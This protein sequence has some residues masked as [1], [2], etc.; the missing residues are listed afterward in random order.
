MDHFS[1]LAGTS[2]VP[3]FDKAGKARSPRQK[4]EYARRKGFCGCCGVDLLKIKYAGTVKIPLTNDNVHQGICIR[5]E[6]D[7]VP[8]GVVTAWELVN[9]PAPKIGTQLSIDLKTKL[10][11]AC[12]EQP[13]SIDKIRY[14]VKDCPVALRSKDVNGSIPLH[15]ACKNTAPLEVVQLLVEQ[16]PEAVKKTTVNGSLPLHY[17][18]SNRAS[19]QVIEY[20][21]EQ[22][23]EAIKTKNRTGRTPLNQE[24]RPE[25]VAWLQDVD[26]GRITFESPSKQLPASTTAEPE[27]EP[28]LEDDS[29]SKFAMLDCSDSLV[30]LSTRIAHMRRFSLW[31]YLR[32]RGTA[33]CMQ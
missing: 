21:V 33:K 25:V 2:R 14:L 16:W 13:Q 28:N 26:A 6:S 9:K 32:N 19:L 20:L 29:A 7:R 5:C 27:P 17:A 8:K 22:W 23:P 30:F 3:Q 1:E 12:S 10:R 31:F 24:T 18:C 11:E 15:Y 4:E